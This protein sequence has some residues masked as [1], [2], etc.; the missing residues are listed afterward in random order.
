[1]LNMALEKKKVLVVADQTQYVENSI[2]SREL[3]HTDK[4]SITMMALAA[5][6]KIS[7]HSAPFD[8]TVM[9][10]DGEAKIT[11]SGQPYILKAGEMIVMPANESH[12]LD[13]EKAFKMVLTMIRG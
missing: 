1:M 12:A 6:Q 11:I 8:A 4:G 9:I 3:V 5:G 10:I 7:E 13:A 2:V